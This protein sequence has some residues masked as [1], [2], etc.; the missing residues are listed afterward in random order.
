MIVDRLPI[1]ADIPEAAHGTS[2][3]P[4]PDERDPIEPD[5]AD[6]AA[7]EDPEKDAEEASW[8]QTGFGSFP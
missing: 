3:P 4:V 8:P 2:V 5:E 1:R 6:E 7:A